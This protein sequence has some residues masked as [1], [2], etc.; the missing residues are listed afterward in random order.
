MNVESLKTELQQVLDNDV[1][2]RKEFNELKR[3]LSDYRNQLIMRDE[4]CKRLQVTID[5]LNTKLVVMERDNTNYKSELT[6]FKELRGSIKEQLDAKQAEIDA[7]LTEIQSLKNDLNAIA[8]DYELKLDNIR[9]EAASELERVKQ[10]YTAQLSELKTNTH[11]KESGIREEFENRLS[12]LSIALVDKEQSL[13]LNHEEEV[14]ALKNTFELQL[15]EL[16][17]GYEA[18]LSQIGSSGQEELETLRTAHNNTVQQLESGFSLNMSE[19]AGKY[20]ARIAELNAELGSQRQQ[21]EADHTQ[22]LKSVKQE[23]ANRELS[24]IANYELKIE[25][26]KGLSAANYEC[27]SLSFQSHIDELRASYE[28]TINQKN[29]NYVS[30]IANL[31]DKYEARLSN[32]LIHSTAQNSRL[33]EELS[34]VQLEND[35]FKEKIRELVIHIDSQNSDIEHLSL[36]LSNFQLQLKNEGQRFTELSAEYESY[37]QNALLSN[38]DQVNELTG[39]IDG[40]SEELKNLGLLLESTTNNLS[41]TELSY[42][43]KTEELRQA[44]LQIDELNARVNSQQEETQL[45]MEEKDTEYQKLL[46]ENTN[47]INEIDLAQDKVEA[48]EAE[49]GLLKTELEEL[50][51]LSAGKTEDFKETLA[52]KN[53]QITNLEANNAAL[54]QELILVKLEVAKLEEQ[55]AGSSNADEAL[56]VLQHN[57][58]QLNQEKNSLMS[59]INSLKEVITGLNENIVDLNH[60]LTGYEAEIQNLK[61]A[62]NTE[63]QDAFIDRLFKQIDALN[64]Q[65]LALLDEKEQMAGQLLKMNDV[66][67]AISQQVESE[68][69]DV[70][71]LNNHRKNV[72]LA[73]NSGEAGERQHMKKQINDLVR[74]IDKCIALLSA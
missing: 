27:M 8:A 25:E 7:R 65:R 30:Q 67:G 40:M 59:E 47:I 42:E 17:N 24:I 2:L 54:N 1:V 43:L 5:V 21:I 52:E 62:G 45:A 48:Y 9:S 61:N 53:F 63:E 55:L 68:R 64:D 19:I 69:I 13:T 12:E 3:S 35:H 51:A 28:Q 22:L 37:R 11:Y 23:A 10:E 73:N 56:G 41:E 16:R 50:K 57:Y 36:Q 6:S 60:K 46:V 58:D 4:D 26:L 29:L 49:L 72:I 38:S 15:T 74:E 44:S 18:R 33:N 70:T 31:A 66:V 14:M 20:E 32:T 71:G 34:K 39:Q